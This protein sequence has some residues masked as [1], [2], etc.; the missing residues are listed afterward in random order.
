MDE[1]K[2]AALLRLESV[3]AEAAELHLDMEN[4]AKRLAELDLDDKKIVEVLK[5]LSGKREETK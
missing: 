4:T 5:V 3:R 2:R 1:L